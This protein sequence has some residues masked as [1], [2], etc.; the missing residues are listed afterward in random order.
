MRVGRAVTTRWLRCERS[1][2]RTHRRRGSISARDGFAAVAT[3]GLATGEA[4]G[5]LGAVADIAV[6][7]RNS[8]QPRGKR[9]QAML[10]RG[11]S[12]GAS[13]SAWTVGGE[14]ENR[15]MTSHRDHH[16]SG[17]PDRG[18]GCP[19]RRHPQGRPGPTAVVDE[20]G[21]RPATTMV[22]ITRLQASLSELEAR[23]AAHGQTVEV[24]AAVGCDLDGELVGARNEADPCRCAPQDQ[25]R[26]RARHRSARSGTSST[27]RRSVAGRPGRGD[28]RRGRRA[29]RGPGRRRTAPPGAGHP[30]RLRRRAR[31]EG[32]ADPRQTDPG[33]GGP[34]GRGGPRGEAV[35][36]GGARGR[37]VGPVVGASRRARQGPV[38]RP[39]AR[40]ALGHAA[41][42]GAGPRRTQ[43]PGRSR[44]LRARP[45][46]A[47]RPQAR[48]GVHR[49]TS[50]T[51]TPTDSPTPAA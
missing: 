12:T 18:R 34:R 16:R 28:H 33:G 29:P 45:C 19:D 10:L 20:P 47:Q 2:P 43:A 3:E 27:R 24:E 21:G 46:P 42:G 51:W 11:F 4:R 35:G 23:V 40:A 50:S 1:E 5:R 44:R 37:C 41:Q 31:R 48:P 6:S 25:A 22:R 49:A 15:P 14:C 8:A 39:A 32:T 13:W 26:R 17:P 9:P 36:Q 38:R 7:G 30:D